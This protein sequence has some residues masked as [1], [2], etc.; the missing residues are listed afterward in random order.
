MAQKILIFYRKPK[1]KKENLL[2]KSFL[3]LNQLF[4]AILNLQFI[5][6]F[7]II[8]LKVI[9]K[10]LKED[11]NKGFFSMGSQRN[12]S[13][14]RNKR[15]REEEIFLKVQRSKKNQDSAKKSRQQTENLIKILE[16]EK[17]RL[18]DTLQKFNPDYD[19]SSIQFPTHPNF[20]H[21]NKHE[22]QFLEPAVF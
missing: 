1:K 14:L 9:C 5:S 20:S 18:I 10:N 2:L 17:N 3:N 7:F 11:K 19:T 6:I 16:D 12:M 13:Q 8:Q 4:V 21:N 15:T 22:Q